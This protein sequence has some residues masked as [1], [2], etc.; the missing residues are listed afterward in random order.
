MAH[1][2]FGILTHLTYEPVTHATHG[3]LSSMLF[4]VNVSYS[5]VILFRKP[6][7][8][9]TRCPLGGASLETVRGGQ[10]LHKCTN[11]LFRKQHITND[12]PPKGG[13]SLEI[14]NVPVAHEDLLYI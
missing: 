3:L 6:H 7:I 13:A 12:A 2:E 5:E 9:K 11:V 10:D 8:S 1:N 14:N 4:F